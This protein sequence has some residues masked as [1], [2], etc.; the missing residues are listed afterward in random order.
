MKLYAIAEMFYSLQHEGVRAGTPAVFIHFAECNL[1]GRKNTAGYDCG[2]GVPIRNRLTADE[3]AKLARICNFRCD[4]VVLTGGEPALQ[5]D[6]DLIQALHAVGFS[7]AIE[8]N[9]TIAL[10]Q[11]TVEWVTVSPRLGAELRVRYA[12]EIKYVIQHG[13][14]IPSLLIP[15]DNCVL[16]PAVD[17]DRLDPKDL[18]WCIRLVKENPQWRLSV[19]QHKIWKIR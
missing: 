7:I 13:D 3:V 1:T 17:G 19:Q 8:T 9:G 11:F 2:A 4:W 6:A 16:S 15:A 14:P 12:D 18:E 5:L 10:D